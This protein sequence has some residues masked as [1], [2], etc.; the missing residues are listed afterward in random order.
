MTTS[1]KT[2]M[3]FILKN[4]GRGTQ[5]ETVERFLTSTKIVS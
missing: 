3:Q 1:K 5:G 2:P 4:W